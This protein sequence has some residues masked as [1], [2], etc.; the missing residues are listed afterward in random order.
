[1]MIAHLPAGYLV[2]RRLPPSRGVLAAGLL[3]SVAP[4]LDMLWWLATGGH[5]HHHAYVT[6]F[7]SV[8][9]LGLASAAVARS[10]VGVAFALNGLV[11]LVLD[12]VVGDIAWFAPFAMRRF[13]LLTVTDRYD[14]WW[15]NF[16][17]HESFAL[18]IGLLGAALWVWRRD[19]RYEAG[20]NQR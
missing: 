2:T 16:V 11:H 14:P 1:M 19:C 4:D 10:P 7:P 15:L 20:S 6:H 13:A 18:E 3:G 8:W 17:L 9:L 12:T 5:T